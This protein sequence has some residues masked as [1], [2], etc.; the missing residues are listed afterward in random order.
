[1]GLIRQTDCTVLDVRLSA[2]WGSGATGD[3]ELQL[4]TDR[5]WKLTGSALTI[6]AV[7]P[8]SSL[9]FLSYSDTLVLLQW[10]NGTMWQL[11]TIE[12]M[13]EDEFVSLSFPRRVLHMHASLLCAVS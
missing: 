3:L 2:T 9:V 11:R 6:R 12:H 10:E 4:A 5:T 1:M 8:P 7:Y 13:N